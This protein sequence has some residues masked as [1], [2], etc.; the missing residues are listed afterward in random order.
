MRAL[1]VPNPVTDGTPVLALD[2]R[3]GFDKVSVKVFSVSG[4]R[5]GFWEGE[6]LSEGPHRYAL[7]LN[8]ANGTYHFLVEMEKDGKALDRKAGIFFILR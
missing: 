3:G 6:S 4:R 2:A 5:A 1:I 7:G 8:L